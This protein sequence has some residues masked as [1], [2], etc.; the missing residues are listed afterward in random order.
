MTYLSRTAK[1]GIAA[2][3]TDATWTAP[4][5]TIPFEAGTRFA[6]HILQLHDTTI[7]A[8]DVVEDQ[9]LQQGPYW[10]DWT[11]NTLA[12][13]DLAGWFLRAMIGPDQYT[14][15]VVTTFAAGSQ[16]GATS[17]SLAAAPPA[18]AVLE[19]GSGA[20][21]EYAQAG[22]PTGAGPYTVPVAS[23]ATG[24]RYA[25]STGEAAQSQAAH[26]FQQNRPA[27]PLWPS[28][29][30]T[31]DDGVET[32]GWPGCVLGALTI[33]VSA[34]DRVS[35]A[36][37]WNGY[38]PVSEATF[39]ENESTTQAPSGWGWTITTAGGASTRGLTLDLTLARALDVVRCAGQQ[40]PL[41]IVP[42][43]LKTTAAYRAIF[44][45]PADLNLYRQALQQPAVWTIAQPAGL[46]G[47]TITVTVTRSGWTDGAVSLDDP[48]RYVTAGFK[49]AGIANT[50]DS[51]ASGVTQVQLKNF[52]QQSYGG[53]PMLDEAGSALLDESSGLI[54]DQAGG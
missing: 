4:A 16:P 17:I 38:P 39:T 32:L 27:G 14:P 18:G 5:F 12:Y 30:L 29:S 21:L 48:G 23:P 24:L 46:G 22:T 9:D 34:D 8:S 1:L 31:T 47:A 50:T 35:F 40:A 26:L 19:L 41:V 10:S 11:V 15:G 37:T 3:T 25:H 53:T 33:R 20:T 43:P 28:W 45:T 13:P 44:D 51:P 52:W 49:L 6:D 36:T 7:R 42:G 54:N 2:E